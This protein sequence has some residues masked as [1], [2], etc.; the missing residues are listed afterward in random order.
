MEE[1]VQRQD[2]VVDNQIS[3]KTIN[4]ELSNLEAIKEM[5]IAGI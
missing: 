5:K 1:E 3:R 2:M 4:Q